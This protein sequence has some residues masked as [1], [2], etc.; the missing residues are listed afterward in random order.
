MSWTNIWV[1]VV[2]ATKH[3][4]PFLND[5]I[6]LKVFFHMKQNAISKGIQVDF[7]NGYKDHA[8]CLISLGREQSLS[9]I[10]Q[11]IKGESSCWINQNK[12]TK[13]KFVWQDDYWAASVSERHVERVRHYI[14]NQ[15]AHHATKTFKEEINAFAKKNNW[16]QVNW[17]DPSTEV[18]AH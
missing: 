13:N 8:H 7:V 11:Q 16:P 3:R 9:K 6:R 5:A 12:L 17:K 18:D 2:F 4:Y 14:I 15:E 1:H 10:V